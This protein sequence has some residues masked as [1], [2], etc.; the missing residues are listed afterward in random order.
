MHL[1]VGKQNDSLKLTHQI[2]EIVYQPLAPVK[3]SIS[4]EHG[5]GLNKKPYLHLSRTQ[6]EIQIMKG[7]KQLFDPKNILNPGRI[8]D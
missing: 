5:I 2:N 7:L 1:I 3:G 4:A 8:V 6:D